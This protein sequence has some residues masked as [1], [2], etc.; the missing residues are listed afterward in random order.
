MGCYSAL[1]GS[2]SL[3]TFLGTA[4][5]S[6]AGEIRVVKSGTGHEVVATN[7][8]HDI[9]MATPAI[10]NGM[11]FVRTQHFLY[12][13]GRT[14]VARSNKLQAVPS[15]VNQSRPAESEKGKGL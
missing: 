10:S 3:E 5:Y 13:I 12:G 4:R 15:G 2:S 11:L 8:M 7:Q 6:N 1:L 14:D 9:C